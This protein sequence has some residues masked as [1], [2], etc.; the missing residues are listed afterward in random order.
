LIASCLPI[1]N[2]P[3]CDRSGRSSHGL[4]LDQQAS[5]RPRL[6][7]EHTGRDLEDVPDSVVARGVRFI[8]AAIL[9]DTVTSSIVSLVQGEQLAGSVS[10]V[11]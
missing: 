5:R 8:E 9:S 11:R 10:V 6:N 4:R 2:V 1:T 3:P 7:R